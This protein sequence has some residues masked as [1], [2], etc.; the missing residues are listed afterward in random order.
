MMN[1]VD[2]LRRIA[3]EFA[4]QGEQK[5]HDAAEHYNY[6]NEREGD[7]SR[8][9][10]TLLKSL[11]DALF[12]VANDITLK[13]KNEFEQAFVTRLVSYWPDV[14]TTDAIKWLWDYMGVVFGDSKHEWGKEVAEQLADDYIREFGEQK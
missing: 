3:A 1:N 9:T 5:Q 4:Y 6:G 13:G 10:A 8:V 11:A 7:V 12:T 14:E 2:I